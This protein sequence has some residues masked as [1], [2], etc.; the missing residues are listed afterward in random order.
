M[1]N[2]YTMMYDTRGGSPIPPSEVKHEGQPY[3]ITSTA[4]YKKYYVFQGWTDEYSGTDVKYKPGD[5]YQRDLDTVFYALYTMTEPSAP[6]ITH[7]SLDN[8]AV[9]ITWEYQGQQTGIITSQTVQRMT[10]NYIWN[11]LSVGLSNEVTTFTDRSVVDGHV[12]RYRIVANNE[13]GS[14]TSNESTNL[15]TD[16]LPPQSI[17]SSIAYNEDLGS[18]CAKISL[19]NKLYTIPDPTLISWKIQLYK[20]NDNQYKPP[21]DP[22]T[23]STPLYEPT[24]VIITND[25]VESGV[26]YKYYAARNILVDN[27]T[28]SIVYIC[29]DWTD[30]SG[31][32]YE[33]WK[34]YAP[35]ISSPIGC[36]AIDK[37]K[38]SLRIEWTHNDLDGSEQRAFRIKQ[39]QEE[40][41]SIVEESNANLYDLDITNLDIDEVY[42]YELQTKGIK[43]EWGD[44]GYFSFQLLQAP[45]LTITKPYH[46]TLTTLPLVTELSVTDLCGEFNKLHITII[47]D[48]D[49]TDQNKPKIINESIFDDYVDPVVTQGSSEHEQLVSYTFDRNEVFFPNKHYY[50]IAF[51]VESTSGLS[52]STILRD[53]YVEYTAPEPVVIKPY[54]NDTYTYPY[55]DVNTSSG[56]TYVRLDFVSNPKAILRKVPDPDQQGE[57]IRELVFKEYEGLKPDRIDLFRVNPIGYGSETEY[58]QN[59][60]DKPATKWGNPIQIGSDLKFG[61]VITDYYC[62][63]NIEYKYIAKSYYNDGGV[64]VTELKYIRKSK[65]SYFL[66]GNERTEDNVAHLTYNTTESVDLSNPNATTV[67]Y[68]D[69]EWPVQ[70]TMPQLGMSV[71]LDGLVFTYDDERKWLRLW[72]EYQGNCFYKSSRGYCFNANVVPSIK[73]ND[74]GDD[75]KWR[76][77]ISL[78]ITRVDGEER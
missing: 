67:Y 13:Y 24:E 23:S 16:P 71:S 17:I 25:S 43:D 7:A 50:T 69:R 57:Y 62:P 45:T 33:P 46:M 10:D 72:K 65:G 55:E 34:P 2:Q 66:F 40:E 74:E 76:G 27:R 63:L 42:T 73:H 14:A 15:Y 59:V 36:P 12:Y 52:S 31:E 78:K 4:P 30:W 19:S 38:E 29:S 11:T 8:N 35:N 54:Y 22:P 37:L 56:E 58:T 60:L 53:F 51:I 28:G 39:I 47:D 70:Y 49:Y 68:A 3:V 64:S 1:A 6:A 61:S 41:W 21:S 48:K 75:A 20:S 26:Q 9:S 18:V 32:V 5:I 44:S 77:T